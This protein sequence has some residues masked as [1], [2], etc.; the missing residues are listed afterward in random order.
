MLEENNELELTELKMRKGDLVMLNIDKCFSQCNG[1]KLPFPLTHGENDENGVVEG[2][3]VCTHEEIAKLAKTNY[4][5]GLDSAGESRLVPQHAMVNL[6]RG[7]S[8]IVVRSR[9]RPIIGYRKRS[10]M[11]L[12]L[13]TVTCKEIYVNRDYLVVV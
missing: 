10:G 9:C 6:F 13:D 1:G 5:R 11:S 3:R 7:A 12:I 4:Y 8:Y 2:Y